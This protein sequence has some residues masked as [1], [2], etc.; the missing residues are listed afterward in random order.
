M[1][2][3]IVVD[4]FSDTMTKPTAEMRRFMCNAEVGDEQKGEDPT[5][6]LLQ[7]MV[8]DLLNKEAAVFLPSGTMCN[9][10]IY[11]RSGPSMYGSPARA[12]KGRVS[13]TWPVSRHTT[14]GTWPMYV[15]CGAAGIAKT[16]FRVV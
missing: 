8:A 2:P 9:L 14:G 1:T 3:K 6:N 13:W 4:L 7:D 15:E 16:T 12:V 5:V 11:L 10:V